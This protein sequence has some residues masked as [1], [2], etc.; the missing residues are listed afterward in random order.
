[1]ALDQHTSCPVRTE[2]DVAGDDHAAQRARDLRRHPEQAQWLSLDL[3]AVVSKFSGA[4]QGKLE[5]GLAKY[6]GCA[7]ASSD[8]Y[9]VAVYGRPIFHLHDRPTVPRVD[10]PHWRAHPD[11]ILRRPCQT[12]SQFAEQFRNVDVAVVGGKDT[13]V[14]ILTQQQVWFQAFDFLP[15]EPLEIASPSLCQLEFVIGGETIVITQDNRSSWIPPS[16][17]PL[18]LRGKTFVG[19][20]TLRI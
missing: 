4:D 20:D 15:C 9:R 7:S 5:A 17:V 14:L 16:R 8:D 3:D 12:P 19:R 11:L 1:M 6:A 13:S 10:A 18:G 2:L